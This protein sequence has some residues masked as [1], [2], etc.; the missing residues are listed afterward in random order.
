MKETDK[1]LDDINI[2]TELEPGD[3]SYVSYRQARLYKEEYNF[4]ISFESYAL[5]GL[6]E[7]YQNYNPE[8]DRVWICENDG[9]IIGFLLLMHRE[10]NAAQLRYFYIEREYRGIGLGKKLMQLYMEFLTKKRYQ[11]S[12]LWTTQELD[13][14]ISLYTRH[15]FILTEEKPS[16]AFGKMTNEWRYDLSNVE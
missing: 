14:A 11:S 3:L 8:M 16:T 6:H 12:Y 2:R 13:S 10:N 5:A 7:F 15:G 1:T 4:G 9:K